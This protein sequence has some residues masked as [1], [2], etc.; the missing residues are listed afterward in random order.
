MA[1]T[2]YDPAGRAVE[3]GSPTERTR[4][5]GRGYTTRDPNPPQQT[6]SRQ[7]EPAEGRTSRRAESRQAESK[8]TEKPKSEG[9][10]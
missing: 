10:E 4:L 6:E 5:L 8:P 2:L 3:V 9:G 7:A 1:E